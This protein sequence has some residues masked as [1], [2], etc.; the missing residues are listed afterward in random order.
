MAGALGVPGALERTSSRQLSASINVSSKKRKTGESVVP[1]AIT[2]DEFRVERNKQGE[3]A[4]AEAII[5]GCKDKCPVCYQKEC[6]GHGCRG[7]LNLKCPECGSDSHLA[8]DCDAKVAILDKIS[9]WHERGRVYFCCP[10]CFVNKELH[11]RPPGCPSNC[12][13]KDRYK[14]LV[15]DHF[16]RLYPKIHPTRRRDEFLKYLDHIWKDDDE[17]NHFICM[18]IIYVCLREKERYM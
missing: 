1:A 10:N 4:Q 2:Q 12:P 3:M 7:N 13:V 6:G 18:P 8:K 15:F 5:E 14:R 16:V 17:S 11:Y 9:F